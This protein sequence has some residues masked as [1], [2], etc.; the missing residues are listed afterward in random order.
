ME[1][2]DDGSSTQNESVRERGGSDVPRDSDYQTDDSNYSY[3]YQ[4]EESEDRMVPTRQPFCDIENQTIPDYA[5]MEIFSKELSDESDLSKQFQIEDVYYS[6]SKTGIYIASPKVRVFKPVRKLLQQI[7]SF[8]SPFEERTES[9]I[10]LLDVNS[11]ETSFIETSERAIDS[12]ASSTNIY[13]AKYLS[14]ESSQLDTPRRRTSTPRRYD[15]EFSLRQFYDSKEEELIS[16]IQDSR[17][18]K[19][20]FKNV[21]YYETDE[22]ARGERRTF[23]GSSR[24]SNSRT[25]RMLK[26]DFDQSAS[27]SSSEIDKRLRKYYKEIRRKNISSSPIQSQKSLW[28]RIVS[29]ISRIWK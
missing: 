18:T 3:S 22:T 20:L 17:K 19:H 16:K 25:S 4:Y 11:E 13:F 1:D 21:N 23:S 10:P 15:Q 24:S 14:S 7:R 9:N 29:T 2:S 5:S 28:S 12:D 26:S 8:I 27:P 6:T